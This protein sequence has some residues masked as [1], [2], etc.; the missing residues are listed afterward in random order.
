VVLARSQA[1]L[2]HRPDV[3]GGERFQLDGGH[4]S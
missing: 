1:Q 4:G 2:A 3:V